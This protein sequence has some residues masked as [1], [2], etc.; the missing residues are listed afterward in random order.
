MGIKGLGG[1]GIKGSGVVEDM[2]ESRE[3]DKFEELVRRIE[4][5]N[6]VLRTWEL[7]GGVSARVTVLEV[8]LPGGLAQRMVVRQ[9]G[10]ADLERNPQIAADEFKLLSMLRAVGLPVPAPYYMDQS[11]EVFPTPYLVVEYIEGKS[12]FA[13]TDLAD[14]ILQFATQLCRIHGVDSTSVDLAFLPEMEEI[15]AEKFRERPAKVDE[16]LDEGHIRDVLEAA[17]PL[18]RR[19]AAVLLHGDYWPGNVLWKDGRLVGVIDWEDA[20]LGDPL[21]DLANS[22]LEVLWAFGIDAMH[23]FTYHYESMASIDF[24]NLPYWDLCAALRP[25]FKIAEWAGDDATERRMRAGHRLFVTQA[26]EKLAIDR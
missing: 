24:T 9:H 8:E 21:A 26:L 4:P 19:N 23:S 14:L 22:R 5:R 1:W 7:K 20:R 18:P 11:G 6:K 13:P 15:Y 16:S 25:A 12:E 2:A 3:D 10:D 17:W